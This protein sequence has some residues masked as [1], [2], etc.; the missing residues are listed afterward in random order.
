[1]ATL[2]VQILSLFMVVFFANTACG[3]LLREGL[4]YT[5]SNEG[6]AM[7]DVWE[8]L[9]PLNVAQL[10]S[11][12]EQDLSK[13]RPYR[14]A[15]AAF[16]NFTME[17]SG[18]W[19][20]LPNGDRIWAL[21]IRCENAKALSVAFSK[22]VL[23]KSGRLYAY[24][25]DRSD[26]IGPISPPEGSVDGKMSIVPIIGNSLMIE[27][28]E[29]L[30]AR[31]DGVIEINSVARAYRDLLA[32]ESTPCLR[33][34][35][36][37]EAQEALRDGAE[38]V[39]L[40]I[41]DNGQRISSGAF[42]NNSQYDGKPY[43]MT[44]RGALEGEPD[45]WVCVVDYTVEFCN[46]GFVCWDRA[47]V[48]GTI[49]AED[50]PTQ[51]VLVQMNE[52][53]EK[54]WDVFFAGWELFN[55]SD[56]R[57]SCVQYAFGAPQ[58]I[59]MSGETISSVQE[60]TKKFGEVRTWS[61]G[62]TFK[63]SIGSPLFTSS[64]RIIGF[65]VKGS[66]SCSTGGSDYFGLL[67]DAWGTFKSFL[68]PIERNT[69]GVSGL[70]S[71]YSPEEEEI[72]QPLV[73]FPNPSEGQLYVQNNSSEAINKVVVYDSMGR[74]V[75]TITPDNPWIDLSFLSIGQYVVQVYQPSAVTTHRV[76]IR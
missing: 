31:G 18:V 61:S 67:S 42:L 54:E 28:Y 64:N 68:D 55:G 25:L 75:G 63:G 11:Q 76:A 1:M 3:Q 72:N 62:N 12:D 6:G 29:P 36:S 57:F 47:I 50:V 69:T 22:L 20:N 60:G 2:K 46:G 39:S 44:T 45:L 23:P 43:L 10:A 5:W 48:G 65:L 9:T 24:A 15:H 32:P 33:S 7:V 37:A 66:S 51:L 30:E 49:V 52:A 21:G 74:Y 58:S 71:A 27:Y 4:P 40:L 59:A 56:S 38:S 16:V 13:N 53:P 8:I 70:Y 41:V 14:F 35:E 17:N 73:L 19:T 34:F 26:F